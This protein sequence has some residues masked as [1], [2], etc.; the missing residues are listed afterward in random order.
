MALN[1]DKETF[2]DNDN[3]TNSFLEIQTPED[4]ADYIEENVNVLKKYAFPGKRIFYSILI[5]PKKD[6]SP[7]LIEAPCDDLKRILRKI[8]DQLTYIYQPPACVHGF[9]CSK[10]VAT[11]AR[12]HVN[13]YFVSSFDIKNF[14][15]SISAKRVRGLFKSIFFYAND[16]LI[17]LLT[18]LVTLHKHLPQGYPTSP[19]IS[20]MI[21]LKMD[22]QITKYCKEKHL[23][24]SRY[25]DDITISGNSKRL[26]SNIFISSKAEDLTLC[27]DFSNIIE[28][29]GFS[30]NPQKTHISFKSD[31]QTVTQ[32]IVNKKCNIPR[33]VYRSLR[34]LF[35]NWKKNGWQYAANEYAKFIINHHYISFK[36][37]INDSMLANERLFK[38]HIRGRL[39][40]YTMIDA[41][42]SIPSAPLT[43][44]WEMYQQCT[45]ERVPMSFIESNV[46]QLEISYDYIA[47]GKLENFTSSST[48]FLTEKG[49]FTCVHGLKELNL[50]YNIP[51]NTCVEVM[52]H[53]RKNS[54]NIPD[55]IPVKDF[56][57]CEEDDIAFY[58]YRNTKPLSNL[59]INFNYFPQLYEH[60]TGYGV[61]GEEKDVCHI[62]STVNS[63][64]LSKSC[65]QI[66][67][68]FYKGMSGGPV[69]NAR[70]EVIGIIIKGSA[71]DDLSRYG[72]FRRMLS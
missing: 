41:Q 12:P 55:T 49:L 31:R 60:V 61:P 11:N 67:P 4:L 19:I 53:S 46:F 17:D 23:F 56:I 8:T 30:L 18:N 54:R 36:N 7:R 44:L 13:K 50:N 43:K 5:I 28:D 1:F 40:Y 15:P 37:D 66:T 52:L 42:N 20:N 32:I 34:V 38:K 3:I 72:I 70:Q 9:V 2:S 35:Y 10:S 16:N 64:K 29:N 22:K 24:Y 59:K 65:V 69:L 63:F 58:P 6:Y 25:A 33:E 68:T 39:A 47:D 27:P 26:I 57:L 48:G 71:V 62:E 51:E 14:F 21:C 45:E